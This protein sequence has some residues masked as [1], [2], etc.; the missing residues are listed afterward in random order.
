MAHEVPGYKMT[1]LTAADVEGYRFVKIN[2][3]GNVLQAAA[4]TDEQ[5]GVSQAKAL[6]GRAC[7]VMVNGISKVEAGGAVTRGGKVSADSVGRAINATVAAGNLSYGIALEAATASG[8]RIA[9]LLFGP[10]RAVTA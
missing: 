5:V 4:Q 10:G 6:S 3:D 7:E 1:R 2:S 8:Q 9:V